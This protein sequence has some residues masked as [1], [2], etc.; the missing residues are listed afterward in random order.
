VQGDLSAPAT[1]TA[2]FDGI[3]KAYV[4]TAVHQDTERWFDNF[5]AAAAQAGVTHLVKYSGLRA[6]ADSPSEIIRQHGRS[7][8]ALVESG[9]PYTILRPNS[10]FQNM[11]WQAESIK[12]SGQFFLP[13]GDAK[14]SQV[15]VRDIAEATAKILTE[16][17]HQGRVYDLTGPESIGYGDVADTLTSLL[18]KS[19][20]YVPVSEEAAR[21]AMLEGGMPEWDA[22]ALAEIQALFGSGV[23][24]G[25]TADLEQLL[26]RRPRAFSDFAKDFAA[27]FGG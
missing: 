12:A 7:D 16:D 25:V 9:I 15:D 26:G 23:Y 5:F 20:T 27:V 10:F 2:A 1:L 22:C 14:L 19:V 4:V 11:L 18:G 8:Q 3:D 17:G 13:I 24:A 6:S 21:A